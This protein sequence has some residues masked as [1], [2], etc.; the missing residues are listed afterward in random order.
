MR[1]CF[2]ERCAAP[3]VVG[4]RAPRRAEL[5]PFGSDAPVGGAGAMGGALQGVG[6]VQW[7]GPRRGW[8]GCSGRSLAE[9]TGPEPVVPKDAS[10]TQ[11]F[12]ASPSNPT[13][14][15]VSTVEKWSVSHPP[16]S[17]HGFPRGTVGVF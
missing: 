2:S 6:R 11:L 8:G 17:L 1:V 3:L 5:C 12:T 13:D 10:A 16:L 7:E 14:L 15:A 9:E 4:Y